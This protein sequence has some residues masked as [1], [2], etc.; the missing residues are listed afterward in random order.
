MNINPNYQNEHIPSS[1]EAM[2]GIQEII[3]NMLIKPMQ[4]K[5]DLEDIEILGDVGVALQSVAEKATA[6]EQ[7]SKGTSDK[8]YRN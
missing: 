5:L 3:Y 6:Y 2:E 1:S 8:N 4:E 7:L